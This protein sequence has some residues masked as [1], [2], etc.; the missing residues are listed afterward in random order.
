MI[1]EYYQYLN[2]YDIIGWKMLSIKSV[3]KKIRGFA[4]LKLFSC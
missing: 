4:C 3:L 1:D 2:H